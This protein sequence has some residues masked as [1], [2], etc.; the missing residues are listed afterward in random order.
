[1]FSK[2]EQVKIEF[3]DI[4]TLKQ[5]LDLAYQK[6]METGD[7]IAAK[8][9]KAELEKKSDAL[10]EKL[11][12]FEWERYDRRALQKVEYKEKYQVKE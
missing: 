4:E 5:E 10:E 6:A 12:A 7:L 1:M 8:K 9:L 3:E 11:L 2:C